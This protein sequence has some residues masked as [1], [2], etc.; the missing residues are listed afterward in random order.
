MGLTDEEKKKIE[1]DEYRK[2]VRSQISHKLSVSADIKSDQRI[3]TH[4]V[5]REIYHDTK[6]AA[7]KTGKAAAHLFI[8]LALA[9]VTLFVMLLSYFWVVQFPWSIFVASDFSRANGPFK[10]LCFGLLLLLPLV[11]AWISII[12]AYIKIR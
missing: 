3:E 2:H 10:T 9:A 5:S 1:E 8:S 12:R 6:H 7:K 11:G 4:G